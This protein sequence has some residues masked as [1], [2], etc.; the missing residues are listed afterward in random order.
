MQRCRPTV[1]SEGS[2]STK[3][4]GRCSP[5][6]CTRSTCKPSSVATTAPKRLSSATRRSMAPARTRTGS[7]S[8]MQA[9]LAATISTESL[10]PA[11]AITRAFKRYVEV[12]FRFVGS[13]RA[14]HQTFPTLPPSASARDDFSDQKFRHAPVGLRVWMAV[15]GHQ[16]LRVILPAEVWQQVEHGDVQFAAPARDGVVDLQQPVPLV[17]GLREVGQHQDRERA[18]RRGRQVPHL[19]NRLP[20]ISPLHRAFVEAVEVAAAH[21]VFG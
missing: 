19:A 14:D 4:T 5:S 11:P 9:S 10:F 17:K 1:P 15:P 6:T 2:R 12:T 7:I 13:E 8:R 18:A 3:T 20:R 21:G 16:K